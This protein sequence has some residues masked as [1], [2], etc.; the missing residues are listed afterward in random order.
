M[1]RKEEEL[2]AAVSETAR[3]NVEV[4]SKQWDSQPER[5]CIKIASIAVGASPKK[6]RLDSGKGLEDPETRL[7]ARAGR[8]DSSV[9]ESIV[10]SIGL[11]RR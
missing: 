10:E 11:V 9:L 7:L 5:P 6:K 8:S 1:P 3:A 2:R 4:V